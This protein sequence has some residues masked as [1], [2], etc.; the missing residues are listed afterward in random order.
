MATV[1][2]AN[3]HEGEL[4]ARVG[5][6]GQHH[7]PDILHSNVANDTALLIGCEAGAEHLP[8]FVV[9]VAVGDGLAHGGAESTS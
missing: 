8:V 9:E 3:A 4:L 6:C 2:I 5:E 7:I 1:T